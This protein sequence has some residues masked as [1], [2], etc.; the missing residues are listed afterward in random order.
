MQMR[1]NWLTLPRSQLFTFL[2]YTPFYFT[3]VHFSSPTDCGVKLFAASCPMLPG[4]IVVSILTSRLGRFRWSIWLGW[5]FTAVGCGCM[6]M[7]GRE[8]TTAQWAAV[9]AIF[10]VGNGMLL[11]GINVGIQAISHVVDCGRAAAMYAFMRTLG[12]S[13]G[14]AIG[15]NVFQNV[16]ANRLRDLSLPA[17]IAFHAESFVRKLVALAPGDPLR[18]GVLDAYSVGFKG[19]FWVMT[20]AALIGFVSSLIIRRHSMDKSLGTDFVFEGGAVPKD[21]P[22]SPLTMRVPEP[23]SGPAMEVR[24]F[25]PGGRSLPVD[26]N[27]TRR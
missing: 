12:M 20:G 8:T 13:I 3:A 23:T 6:T 11:T 22:A 26:I 14:V 7:F 19:V 24:V 9:L 25:L 15:G 21:S 10:G 4:S 5:V 1:P 2:Y 17:E 18:E 27:G 16:M